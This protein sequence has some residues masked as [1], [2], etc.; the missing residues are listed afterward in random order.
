MW[1]II[2]R[3]E[4]FYD[5]IAALRCVV[6]H[7]SRIRYHKLKMLQNLKSYFRYIFTCVLKAFFSRLTPLR[8]LSAAVFIEQLH[9]APLLILRFLDMSNY[10]YLFR[11][12]YLGLFCCVTEASIS[13]FKGKTQTYSL[14]SL[15]VTSA[16]LC[17]Q[18][19]SDASKQA[20]SF[21]K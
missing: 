7:L 17:N 11:F 9:L 4:I 14:C 5:I 10:R 6:S 19:I 3:Q 16:K 15:R 13:T 8:F 20:A 21:E 18:S 12:R 1:I 2:N